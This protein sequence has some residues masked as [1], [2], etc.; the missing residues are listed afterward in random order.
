[1]ISGQC[2]EKGLVYDCNI[3]GQVD[4]YYVGDVMKLKQVMINILSNA[5]KFTPKGGK[6][7]FTI[8]EGR[9]YDGHAVLHF[10]FRDTGIGMSKEFLPH[11]FEAFSQEDSSSTSR[12]GSTGLG[13]PITKSIVELMNGHMEVESE[14][15]VGTTFSVTVTLGESDR[16]RVPAEEGSSTP[17]T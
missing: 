10:T 12:Y 5:V 3:I 8:E 1:M 4:D 7:T 15:G 11:L 6:V 13:M 9:R 14:K 17:A 2:R 16:K